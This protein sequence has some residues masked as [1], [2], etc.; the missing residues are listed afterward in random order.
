MSSP[1]V[2]R[3]WF[4]V[5]KQHVRRSL[6]A[7]LS[8]GLIFSSVPQSR[9]QNDPLHIWVG[10]LDRP[11]A[12]KW[13]GYHLAREQRFV[14]DVL[15]VKG[16]RTIENTLRPFDNAQNELTIAG[17]EAYLMYAVAPQKEVRDA[18]QALAQQVQQA[19]TVLSLNQEVYRALAAV[20]VA[21]ADPAGWSAAP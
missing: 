21:A 6:L 13:V 3:L 9:A 8:A 18:G 2:F 14:D 12:E 10:R 5:R 15:A 7:L 17:G 4:D 1:F 20:E 16:A 19:A 11:A